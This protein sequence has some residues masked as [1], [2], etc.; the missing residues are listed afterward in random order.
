[1]I[2]PSSHTTKATFSAEAEISTA[3][4]C[5]HPSPVQ[6][7]GFTVAGTFV[8][9]LTDEAVSSPSRLTTSRDSCVARLQTCPCLHDDADTQNRFRNSHSSF[10]RSICQ[11]RKSVKRNRQQEGTC[12]SEL[13]HPPNCEKPTPTESEQDIQPSIS[14]WIFDRLS[15]ARLSCSLRCPRPHVNRFFLAKQL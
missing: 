11:S 6:T 10:L 12:R 8:T 2:G 1:V 14:K 5:P 15:T 7:S 3:P 9:S 13:M 4:M